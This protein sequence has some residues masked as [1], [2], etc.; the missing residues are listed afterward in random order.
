MN[1]SPPDYTLLCSNSPQ[2]GAFGAMTAKEFGL[3]CQLGEILHGRGITTLEEAQEYLFPHLSM[4]PAPDTMKGMPEAVACIMATCGRSEP[5]FV[6]GDY[7]VD[8]ISATALLVSF[9]RE[10][11]REAFFHIPN[12]LEESYGLS[13]ISINRLV[14]Q[15]P[16][17]GGVLISADCGISAVREVAYARHLGLRVVVTDHHEPQETLPCA[18]A[19]LNPKQPGCTFPCASLSGVGVAFFLIMA[20]RKAMG[21]DVNLKKYL[22]F[23]ALG[24]VADA[25]PLVGANRILVRAGLEVLSAK[26]RVGVFSLCQSAGI[27]NR[28]VLS[29]DIAFKLAPR[30]NAS[31][32]L[33]S[34]QTGVALLLAADMHQARQTAGELDRMNAT[35]RQFEAKALSLIEVSCARQL[36][37]GVKGL[38]VYH[39]DCHPGVL[40]I[41]ASRLVDRCHRPAIVF[42]DDVKNGEGDIVRGS[43]RSINGVSLFQVLEQCSG[44]I[45]QFGGHAMAVGL[46]VKKENIERFAQLFDNQIKQ[47]SGSLQ[48]KSQ[49][50]VDYR[51][52]NAALLSAG[53]ARALQWLQPFGEGNLEPIF[54]LSRQ[55]LI[56]PKAHNG[57]L[58]FQVQGGG[59]LFPGIGF[60]LGCSGINA[61]KTADLVFQLKRSWFKGVERNQVHALMVTP[62]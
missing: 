48:S 34:P 13:I 36:Q 10:I 56:A 59:Q 5:I 57:H 14:A 37:A 54:L 62:C 29:E 18:D 38:T 45:E 1:A 6:H 25:V 15:C 16:D 2:E 46:T 21:V 41:L 39:P 23:V 20:L 35:R 7:D 43:G 58:I 24:T 47:F 9:F 61:T 31:G 28:E 30:I 60:H 33:G 4:L 42:G 12:R 50:M 49:V 22:D 53:F 26:T 3:P 51:M 55:K 32:R 17:R 19:I 8:G 27:E 44:V 52:Q 40:G 11:N